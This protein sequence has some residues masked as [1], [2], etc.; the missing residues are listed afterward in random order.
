MLFNGLYVLWEDPL[1]LSCLG[2]HDRGRFL[3]LKPRA[4]V[5]CFPSWL[6]TWGTVPG[7][8]R[9]YAVGR[10]HRK[11]LHFMSASPD[12]F[13]V[14]GSLRLPGA[15]ISQNAYIDERTFKPLPAATKRFSAVYSAQMQSFKRLHLAADL[16]SLYV[17]TYGDT[18]TPDG[19]F[20]LHRFEPAVSHADYNR[21]WMGLSD[22][23]EVYN[24]ASVGLA[25]S[26]CEGAMLACVEYMLAGLP[27][28]STPCRGGRELFFDDRFVLVCAPTKEAVATGVAELT[29]R[30]IDPDVVRSATL[31][32][33]DVHRRA[34]C[35]Y[36]QGIIRRSRATTPTV[37]RLYERIFGGEGGA[38]DLFVRARDF[39]SRGWS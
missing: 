24:G 16:P 33:L 30:R 14:L 23:N 31:K 13:R 26:E 15:L 12:E 38:R 7:M 20:D 2:R 9:D 27:M 5:L 22:I 4:D 37:D 34:L 3:A 1:I 29:R 39:A 25:L 8:L 19:D 11:R 32:R 6:Q 35:A 18:V 17:V 28:L 21:R 10:R 36:V